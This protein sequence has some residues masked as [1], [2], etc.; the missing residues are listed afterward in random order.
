MLGR[1][2]EGRGC[3]EPTEPSQIE[4]ELSRR[5]LVLAPSKRQYEILWGLSWYCVALP[6]MCLYTYFSYALLQGH[7]VLL[8]IVQVVG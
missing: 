4:L 3:T 2:G 6:E 1:I 8:A 7:F 5:E